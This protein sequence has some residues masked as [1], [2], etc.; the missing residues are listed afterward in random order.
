MDAVNL[1]QPVPASR[2]P[3]RHSDRWA[4]VDFPGP[5]LHG[6]YSVQ[7]HERW[8]KEQGLGPGL[9]RRLLDPDAGPCDVAVCSSDGRRH[10]CNDERTHQ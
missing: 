3:Y 6:H 9:Y 5:I 10:Y 2:V 7:Y 1:S 8:R 4:V